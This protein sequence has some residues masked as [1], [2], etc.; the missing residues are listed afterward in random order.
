VCN[1][2]PNAVNKIIES[3]KPDLIS[4]L[5]V[6]NGDVTSIG[7]RVGMKIHQI[8]LISASVEEFEFSVNYFSFNDC[9]NMIGRVA[10]KMGLKFGHD[11]LWLPL[12]DGDHMFAKIC[13]TRDF[14]E[15][16]RFMDYNPRVFHNGFA[17]LEDIFE[18]VATNGRFNKEIFLLE[19]RN[20]IAKTRERKRKTYMAFLEWVKTR[21]GLAE[22]EWPKDKSVWLSRI[23]LHFP[24]A[25]IEYHDATWNLKETKRARELFN[26]EMVMGLTGL[27][28]KELGKFMKH[29]K[30]LPKFSRTSILSRPKEDT[31]NFIV[32]EWNIYKENFA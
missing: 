11:G 5:V 12:R 28:G 20:T 32:Q 29:L 4:D 16:L 13:L 24:K 23:F 3:L 14:D 9:G 1:H 21:Q 19:N 6:K 10:H 22:F 25:A 7:V 26:G 27:E 2:V 31:M 18:Y 30:D 8:D 15:A 17:T